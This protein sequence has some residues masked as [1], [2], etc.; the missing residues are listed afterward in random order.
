MSLLRIGPVVGEVTATTARVLVQPAV[1]GVVKVVLTPPNGSGLAHSTTADKDQVIVSE[2][3]GLSAATIY[4]MHVTIDDR[5]VAGG[6]GS[7]RVTTK[8]TAPTSLHMVAVSCNFTVRQGDARLW[9]RVREKWV[10]PG[11][12]STV[13]HV[14]DQIYGDSA[15]A[16]GL[17]EVRTHG[18]TSAV[19]RRI[20]QAFERLYHMSW[21]YPATRWV[22]AH[23]SNLMIW[24][25]HEVRNSWGGYAVDRDPE[26]DEFYVGGIAREVFQQYQANSACCSSTSAR[27]AASCTNRTARTSAPSNGPGFATNCSQA[28]WP[29]CGH[30]CS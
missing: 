5:T 7:G 28:R 8:P 15:F 24:D 11:T 12:V 30:S 14:G 20:R 6:L 2:F 18:R 22:L 25:D 4:T 17:A 9:E 19:R 1:K 16:E 26:S 13:L 23:A 21:S 3:T 27:V 29:R 10:Q